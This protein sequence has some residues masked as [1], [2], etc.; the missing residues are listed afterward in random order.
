MRN[1]FL[2]PTSSDIAAF[3][4]AF[5]D[6]RLFDA[7]ATQ[8]LARSPTRCMS[9]IASSAGPMKKNDERTPISTF[10]PLC[11]ASSSIRHFPSHPVME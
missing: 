5:F 9:A 11:A 1:T 2:F 3:L 6:T 8:N 7:N 10:L 4:S